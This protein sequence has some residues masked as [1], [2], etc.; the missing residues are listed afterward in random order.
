MAADTPTRPAL[1][2]AL[3]LCGY[4]AA[5]AA[6]AVGMA[7]IVAAVVPPGPARTSIYVAVLVTE[8]LAAGLGAT[9]VLTWIDGR[10]RR[11]RG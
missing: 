1:G 10:L 4:A 9:R 11:Q 2:L 8:V 7:A 6:V 3:A 5:A